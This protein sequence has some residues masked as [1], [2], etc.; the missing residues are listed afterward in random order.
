MK[1]YVET[2]TQEQAA[3][4]LAHIADFLGLDPQEIGEAHETTIIHSK[5]GVKDKNGVH[6][7]IY[8]RNGE[9]KTSQRTKKRE[10]RFARILANVI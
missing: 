6:I 5:L 10:R 8:R 4:E 2:R 3:N 9:K 7:Y 1:I